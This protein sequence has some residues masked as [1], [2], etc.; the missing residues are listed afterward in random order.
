[1]DSYFGG[2][3]WERLLFQRGLAAIYAIAFVSALSQ[4][5][6]LLGER[7]LL[8]APRFLARVSFR[9]APSL[10]HVHYSDRFF[11][12]V[13]GAGLTLSLCALA[14]LPERGP[15][16]L[17]VVVWLGI[18]VSYLSI[19]NVGQTFYAFG[20]ESML[21]EAGFFAAFMGPA[22]SAPSAL[23]IIAL[24]WL[25]FR[26][27]F[28]AGLIKLRHDE[29]WRDLTCLHY[30]FET[31]PM[32]NGLSWYFHRQP[33][34]AHRG[35]VLFS[36]FVQLIAPFGLFM[37]QPIAASAGVLM[38]AH[39]GVLIVSGNYAWLNW[40]TVVLG[41]TAFSDAQLAAW[42]GLL[43]PDTAARPLAYDIVLYAL[44]AITLLLSIQPAL[45]LMR[46]DQAMN[47][48]YNSLHLVNAY[49]AFGSVTRE[50]REIVLEGSADEAGE[51]W[52]EYGFKGKPGDPQRRPPQVAP[53][54]LRLDWLI[55]FVPLRGFAQPERWLQRL[56]E[57]LLAGDRAAL[58]L[59]AHNPFPGAPPRQIRAL[60]Y[61]YRFTDARERAQ[62]GAWWKREY[63]GEYFRVTAG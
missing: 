28:G 47:A 58:R 25:L 49:G 19:V 16:W 22:H 5:P 17:S 4:F 33:R 32:P 7:G 8:P 31:Q 43:A 37:P 63:L 18:W 34:W 60:L 11:R 27:E 21:L 48:S 36:H 57:L 30:H 53:Y 2:L 29:C 10:F 14:G 62:S 20:W 23:P 1:M 24:R 12:L 54:H 38:I 6:V 35:G 61:Q 15:I 41:L 42:F 56:L 51:V 3:W 44:A 55:W 26:S 40:L 59:L 45:N 52:K 13:A 50:R 39:Q 46:K 9:S